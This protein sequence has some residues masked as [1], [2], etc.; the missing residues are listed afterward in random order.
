MLAAKQDE[1]CCATIPG[2]NYFYKMTTRLTRVILFCNDVEKLKQF[3]QQHFTF[4][5]A[6]E[7]KNEWVVLN[8]GPIEIAFHRIGEAYRNQNVKPFRIESNIKLVL[9]T[10]A[11]ITLFRTKLMQAGVPMQEIKSFAGY[12]YLFCDGEDTEGN[13]FQIV[14]PKIRLHSHE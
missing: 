11:N 1:L 9:S 12:N 6:E 2:K 8:A 14:T 7:I 13:V 10:D 5:I 4:T 3:Y